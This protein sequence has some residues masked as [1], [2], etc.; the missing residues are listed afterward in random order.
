MGAASKA[1]L[2]YARYFGDRFGSAT[3]VLHAQHLDLPPY[4]SSGQFQEL[5]R[6]LKKLTK[7]AADHLRKESESE[8]GSRADIRVVDNPPVEAILNASTEAGLIIM[9]MHGHRGA[10]RLWLGSVTERVIRRSGIPVLA[11]H[12]PPSDMPVRHILCPMTPSETGTQALEYSAEIARV[13]DA[14]LTV[15]HVVEPGDEPLTCP[16]VGDL[17]K[18]SCTVEEI[19]LHGNA[20]KT[21]MESYGKMKPDLMVLGA[22]RKAG[23]MGEF[24]SSTTAS[25]M[26]LA[27]GPLMIVPKRY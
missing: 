27:A 4:F 16:L 6:E 22:G 21:I 25:I 5:K 9:G 11:V 14:R 12:K 8:L 15:L 26:Q 18:S 17:I 19:K 1:A 20:A 7:A 2:Q 3:L 13:L 10:E 23:L 24:F